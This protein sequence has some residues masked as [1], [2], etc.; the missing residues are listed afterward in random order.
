MRVKGET[1][2]VLKKPSLDPDQIILPVSQV[3]NIIDEY[4]SKLS[5][6]PIKFEQTVFTNVYEELKHV[7]GNISTALN[8]YKDEIADLE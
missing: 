3:T 5:L 8:Y 2:K 4:K 6:V 1:K 7:C